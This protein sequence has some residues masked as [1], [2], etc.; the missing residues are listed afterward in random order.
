MGS[1][2]M[3]PADHASFIESVLAAPDVD[4][5]RHI[6][7][8]SERFNAYLT[9]MEDSE[10]PAKVVKKIKIASKDAATDLTLA[11]YSRFNTTII[12]KLIFIAQLQRVIR[13]QLSRKL[14]H[15]RDVLRSSHAGVA[16]EVTEYGFD[17]YSANEVATSRPRGLNYG[18]SPGAADGKWT[19]GEGRWLDGK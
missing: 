16:P 12:R 4:L 17:P 6:P 14:T 1:F 15:E 18:V 9:Y 8:E 19:S 10:L 5:P 2:G 3:G 7:S 13:Q 11:G